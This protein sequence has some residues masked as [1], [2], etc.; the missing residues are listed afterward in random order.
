M[1][2]CEIEYLSFFQWKILEHLRSC[3]DFARPYALKNH[4]HIVTLGPFF[5]GALKK[6]RTFYYL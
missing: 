2:W 5:S 3:G 4:G 6:G 1:Y